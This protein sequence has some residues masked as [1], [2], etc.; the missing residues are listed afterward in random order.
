M[1][2]TQNI[3]ELENFIRDNNISKNVYS[4][5][6]IKEAK[7]EYQIVSPNFLISDKATVYIKVS[8]NYGAI[9]IVGDKFDPNQIHTSFSPKYQNYV[10]DTSNRKLIIKGKSKKYGYNYE[11]SIAL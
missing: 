5:I 8:D 3:N 10:Y 7:I 11:V 4:I 1:D 6:S 2:S 9:D